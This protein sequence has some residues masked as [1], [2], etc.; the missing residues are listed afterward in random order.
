MRIQWLW[1]KYI[2]VVENLINHF[3]IDILLGIEIIFQF[4]CKETI[5]KSS[6]PRL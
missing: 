2:V 5:E 4:D 6:Q 3:M 1:Y